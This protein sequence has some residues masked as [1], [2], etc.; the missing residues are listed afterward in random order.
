MEQSYLQEL[1][2]CDKCRLL[3]HRSRITQIDEENVCPH[4]QEKTCPPANP[5]AVETGTETSEPSR[6]EP[7]TKPAKPVEEIDY[8]AQGYCCPICNCVVN[9]NVYES[10][11]RKFAQ[12]PELFSF[13]EETA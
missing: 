2:K 8:A 10:M 6:E 13:S 12:Y 3:V 4:C 5:Q 1:V 9:K 7:K 11:K